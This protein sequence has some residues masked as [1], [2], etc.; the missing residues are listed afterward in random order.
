MDDWDSYNTR[1]EGRLEL[2]QITGVTTL[3]YDGYQPECDSRELNH[4]AIESQN[5]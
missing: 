3:L 1:S 2:Q 4:D 5:D